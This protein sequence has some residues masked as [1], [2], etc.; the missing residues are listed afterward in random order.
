[1]KIKPGVKTMIYVAAVTGIFT[2]VLVGLAKLL[3]V[4]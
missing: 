3:G 1:M 2:V 4:E